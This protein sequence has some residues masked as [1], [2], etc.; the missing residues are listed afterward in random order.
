MNK[1]IYTI[2]LKEKITQTKEQ[3]AFLILFSSLLYHICLILCVHFL[4]IEA[5]L[6]VIVFASWAKYNNENYYKFLIL[7]T[8]DEL[9]D[10][11]KKENRA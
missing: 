10:I 11:L 4:G 3:A 9:L 5:T 8:N 2:I 1:H 6:A 7:K